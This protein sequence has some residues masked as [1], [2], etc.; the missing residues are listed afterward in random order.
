MTPLRDRFRA[1]RGLD[2]ALALL[3]MLLV[4][5]IY[6]AAGP[7]SDDKPP[8]TVPV[9]RGTILSTVSADGTVEP[10]REVSLGFEQGGR[11]V[12]VYVDEGDRVRRGEVLARVEDGPA[13][14]RLQSA[15]ENL[16]SAEARLRQT[17]EGRTRAEL[18][19]N[20]RMADQSRTA[21]RN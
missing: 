14:T 9:Q 21:V 13:R 3:A 19:E 17:R 12:A 11:L 1:T 16:R 20:Q 4:W 15:E 2:V 8:E 6:A 18:A 5:A 7:A 10:P